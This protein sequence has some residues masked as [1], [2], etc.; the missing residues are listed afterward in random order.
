MRLKGW[1][2]CS[3][4]HVDRPLLDSFHLHPPLHYL[5]VLLKFH[6][7]VHSPIRFILLL[8]EL[9]LCWI[10][11]VAEIRRVYWQDRWNCS[12]GFGKTQWVEHGLTPV[13][14][15]VFQPATWDPRQH[16]SGTPTIP[17]LLILVARV[18]ESII[19]FIDR[20]E[21]SAQMRPVRNPPVHFILARHHRA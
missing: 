7:I 17:L 19:L 13:V 21:L 8:T 14:T 15:F 4:L 3:R 2:G 18:E 16:F 5:K 10:L 9:T 1:G 6:L 20:V 11:L 12:L